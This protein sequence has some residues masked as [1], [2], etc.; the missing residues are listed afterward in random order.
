MTGASRVAG[1]LPRIR[2]VRPR[3]PAV[4]TDA[5]PRQVAMVARIEQAARRVADTRGRTRKAGGHPAEPPQLGCI[6]RVLRVVGTGKVSHQQRHSKAVEGRL[7]DIDR[8]PE[9]VHPGVDVHRDFPVAERSP[10]GQLVFMVDHRNQPRFRQRPCRV[11]QCPL[12]YVN[13]PVPQAL[14][15]AEAFRGRGHEKVPAAVPLKRR[16]RFRH[17]QAVAVRLDHRPAFAGHGGTVAPVVG[18]E[19]IAVDA[20]AC[21]HTRPPTVTAMPL[22]G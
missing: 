19:G 5:R 18:G 10:R 21:R 17:A 12:E 11:G 3:I 20:Q 9:P 13:R 2:G 14:P 16:G 1:R 7:P 15:E 4:K 22:P 6:Q 8:K